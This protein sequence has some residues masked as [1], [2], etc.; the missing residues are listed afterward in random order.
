MD[1]ALLI[2]R[3]VVG[4]LLVG[5]GSQKLFGWFGGPGL[6]GTA[7]FLGGMLGFRPATPWAWA[8]ALAETLGGLG[9]LLGFLNPLGSLGIAASMLTAIGSVHWG[10]GPWATNGGW[11]LPLTNLAAVVAVGLI[12]PGRYSVDSALGISLPE[13][14]TWIV[15]GLL[16][17]IGVAVGLGTRSRQPV[18]AS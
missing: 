1:I 12:G 2:L 14:W 8:S 5:H 13:P 17:I 6:K 18:Q 3:V 16:V 11:E 15:V 10:K 7:G 9:L 4:L